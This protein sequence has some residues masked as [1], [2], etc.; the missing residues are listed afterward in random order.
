MYSSYLRYPGYSCIDFLRNSIAV[1]V[2]RIVLSTV[3][4]L[5]LF[6]LSA[7]GHTVVH[8]N[9]ESTT[10]TIQPKRCIALQQG[11]SCFATLTFTWNTPDSGEYCLF[12]IRQPDSL[13]C[14]AGNSLTTFRQ[15]FESDRNVT[16]EIR[17]KSDNR[18]LAKAVVK[19][20]WVYK[21]NN[22]STS[23]WRVF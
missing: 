3:V 9:T 10:L 17:L 6:C 12:D 23:R 18:P 14:W 22:S 7:F 8:A 16:Y 20:S 13:V 19:I 15:K 5:L 2:I 11:Q 4:A 1:K 21:S